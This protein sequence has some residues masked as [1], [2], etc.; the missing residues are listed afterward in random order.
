MIPPKAPYITIKINTVSDIAKA[1]SFDTPILVKKYIVVASLKPRPPID[2][3]SKVMAPIIG[4]KI[5]K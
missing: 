3:G 1:K 5:K 4:I 2:I